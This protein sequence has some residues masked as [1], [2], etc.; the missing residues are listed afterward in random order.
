MAEI[1]TI[2]EREVEIPKSL[3]ILPVRD[4]V[5]FPYM[6]LPLFV[7][8]DMSIKAIEEASG[9][10]KLIML[11]SQKDVNVE[12]PSEDDLYKVGTVGTILRMLKLP[13][14]RLKILVQGIAKAKISNLVKTTKLLNC[15]KMMIEVQILV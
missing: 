6:I 12:T 13:D 1:D 14:G 5:I 8:R 2:E 15:L 7:G 4:V 3:P 11:V 9:E 10:N